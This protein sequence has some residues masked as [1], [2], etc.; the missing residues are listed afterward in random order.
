MSSRMMRSVSLLE[1][2]GKARSRCDADF[3]IS[4]YSKN[5]IGELPQRA[6][7]GRMALC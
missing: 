4:M 3:G 5:K 6:R 2:V 7:A 1:L